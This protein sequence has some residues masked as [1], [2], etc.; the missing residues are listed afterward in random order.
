[1]GIHK[2]FEM[3]YGT[4]FEAGAGEGEEKGRGPEDALVVY[5]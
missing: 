4:V 2:E 1:M 3:V 5:I